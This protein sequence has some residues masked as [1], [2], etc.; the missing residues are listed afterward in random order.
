M[1]QKRKTYNSMYTEEL[2]DDIC[3]KIAASQK[4]L[5]SLCRENKEAGWPRAESIL[6]WVFQYPEF[7]KK[8][9]EARRIQSQLRAEEIVEIAD[10]RDTDYTI[11]FDGDAQLVKEN[12]QRSRLRVDAR[13]WESSK[14]LPRIYGDSKP[15]DERE[16]EQS[17]LEKVLSGEY[18]LVKKN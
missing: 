1:A 13:K 12:I 17:I 9:D 7:K 11:N 2:A 5:R 18:E 10:A 3:S 4:G 15:L 14:I 6:R 16:Q 8:Y